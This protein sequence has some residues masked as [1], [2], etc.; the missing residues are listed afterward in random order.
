M[1]LFMQKALAWAQQFAAFAYFDS[2]SYPDKLAGNEFDAMLAVDSLKLFTYNEIGA[3][4][5]LHKFAEDNNDWLIGYLSYDLKNDIEKL[6]SS[7]DDSLGFDAVSFF[8]P[9]ILFIQ[10]QAEIKMLYYNE[11]IEKTLST[12]QA[13]ECKE[14]LNDFK[15]DFKQ[16]V[17]RKEYIENIKHI[18]QDISMG[19]IYELNYCVEFYNEDARINPFQSYTKLKSASPTPF[20]AFM[21][22]N[23]KYII[24][25]S[26]ER[27]LKKKGNK[28]ISQPIKGTI[29]RG[30]DEIEDEF[31]K[32]VLRNSQKEQSENVMIV[33]LVRNDLSHVAKPASVNVSELFGIYTYPSVHQMISTVEAELSS[34]KN[35]IDALKT[36]FPMGSMTGAPKVRAMK[37][38]EEYEITKRGVYS[39]A[40]GYITPDKDFDFNVVIRTLLYNEEKNYLS[41]SVGGAIT[42]L[43]VAE[44]EYAECLLKAGA[45]FKLFNSKLI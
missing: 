11:N 22:F 33:D 7:N 17:P 13:F 3:F 6:L 40:I 28:L 36:S 20:S 42:N 39:G 30:K 26:P 43:S 4:D 29:R 37:L 24:S 5:S 35:W 32:N 9:R 34:G 27:Y 1:V 44:D 23:K 18:K 8:I 21:A 10:K 19:E 45:L 38:I 16:K 12:I 25:A 31:L 41:V 2:S 15:L 14:K